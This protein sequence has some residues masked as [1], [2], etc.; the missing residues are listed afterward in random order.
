MS[1]I[2]RLRLGIQGYLIPF[3]PLAFVLE[4]QECSSEL[5]SPS[6]FQL[7]L[8]DLT[9]TPAIPLAFPTLYHDSFF[10]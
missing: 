8:T 7:I 1:S 2:H 5:L 10:C 3:S 4:R 6:V 9:P